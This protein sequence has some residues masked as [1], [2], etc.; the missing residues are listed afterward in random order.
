M[1]KF[2]H[3]NLPVRDLDRSRDWWVSVLGLMVEFEVPQRRAVALQDSGGF[4]IFLEEKDGAGA[5]GVA[6]WFKVDDVDA[7]FRTWTERDRF[8]PRPAEDL[9]GLRRGIGR[10]RR[11]RGAP[12]G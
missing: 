10:S 2:D 5:N 1:M 9:L 11:L 7:A 4:A 8:R 3:L 6:L 12:V